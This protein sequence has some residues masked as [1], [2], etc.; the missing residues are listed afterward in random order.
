MSFPPHDVLQSEMLHYALTEIAAE[1]NEAIGDTGFEA[2]VGNTQGL[3]QYVRV[4]VKAGAIML[5]AAQRS[6]G[7]W[8]VAWPRELL[9]VTT[10]WPL[11]TERHLLVEIVAAVVR[12]GLAGHRLPSPFCWG[13]LEC[14]AI[15]DL[16]DQ[17]EVLGVDHKA[18]AINALVTM[19]ANDRPRR[20]QGGL[21][22]LRLTD[23]SDVERSLTIS[24]DDG[25]GWTVDQEMPFTGASGRLDLA[26]ALQLNPLLPRVRPDEVDVAKLARLLAEDTFWIE[27][28]G[29][30]QRHLARYG[31]T[32]DEGDV[33]SKESARLAAGA[34]LVWAG[35]GDPVH[36]W[37]RRSDLTPAIELF[38]DFTMAQVGLAAVQ[39]YKGIAAAS[40][41]AP[42]VVARSWFSKNALRW[43]DS[44]EMLLFSIDETGLLHPANTRAHAYTPKHMGDRPL[45]C[46]DDACRAIGCVLEA[47]YCPSDRGRTS[48][49]DSG[50]WRLY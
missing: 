8:L 12:Q 23:K 6:P 31:Q 43:A 11:E 1:L 41:R 33:N 2:E 3:L 21:N 7:A 13:R 39:R 24:F 32:P 46:G 49:P 42:V 18:I 30:D 10:A 40:G 50:R 37:A 29:D 47:E 16:A 9:T 45:N 26:S 28:L 25:H 5:A 48:H 22:E 19:D 27:V 34:W 15:T 20:T 4:P 14:S 17:L 38:I 36:R 44:A 35:F